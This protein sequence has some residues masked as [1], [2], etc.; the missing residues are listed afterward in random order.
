M[1]RKPN[2]LSMA[3]PILARLLA[4]VEL[5]SDECAEV[6]SCAAAY[7]KTIAEGEVVEFEIAIPLDIEDAVRA[8][9]VDGISIAVDGD[10]GA[11]N[12]QVLV[13]GD[14]FA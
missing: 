13:Q 11:D 5:V 6:E 10:I 7:G 14:A 2:A 1:V 4:K 3:P 8:V 12:R 9:A